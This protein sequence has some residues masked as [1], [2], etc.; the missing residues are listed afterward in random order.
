MYQEN[1]WLQ[2]SKKVSVGGKNIQSWKKQNQKLINANST[3]KSFSGP[4]HWH[5][6]ELQQGIDEFVF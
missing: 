6:Q 1:E 5:F 2:Y 4:K 3:Q